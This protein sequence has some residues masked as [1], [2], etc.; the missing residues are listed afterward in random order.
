MAT[1]GTELSRD[2]PG[3][4]LRDALKGTPDVMEAA[5]RIAATRPDVIVLQGI[6]WDLEGRAAAALAGRIAEA[7]H[8]L[9]HALHPPGN[10]GVP[11]GDLDGDGRVDRAADMH[12]WGF[13]RGQGALAVLSRHPLAVEADLSRLLWRDMPGGAAPGADGSDLLAGPF[14]ALRLST[15]AHLA[16]RVDAPGGP[17]TLLVHHATPPVF[18]GPED[19]NGRR[20]AAELA[21]WSEYLD[22]ALASVPG[23][24]PAP[25][26]PVAL[27]FAANIDP[28]DGDGP[29]EAVRAFLSRPDIADPRPRGGGAAE[30]RD[31][32]RGDPALDTVRW[33]GV[34]N[35]RV[36]Y[37]LAGPGTRA[38]DAGLDWPAPGAHSRHALVWAD[39]AIGR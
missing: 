29:G 14:A 8:D 4:L 34:G 31:G 22:G 6:D 10:R 1:F 15:T 35:L 26:G 3:L 37:V 2:G 39:L 13:F 32:D 11:A 33:D 5:A 36:D 19:R 38:T 7:G 12:G 21:L 28:F 24:A 23:G 18:D 30:P 9:P 20:A 27:A 25:S 17:L 16:V